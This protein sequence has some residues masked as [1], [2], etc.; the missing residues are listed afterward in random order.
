[1][2]MSVHEQ[3]SPRRTRRQ[4]ATAAN[5]AVAS[6]REDADIAQLAAAEAEARAADHQVKV[7]LAAY[8]I[9]EKRGF[10]PGHEF[11]DWLAAEAEIEKA[12]P[13]SVLTSIQLS[14]AG[15]AS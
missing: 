2:H 4:A 3:K 10:E 9:A 14:P 6:A 7:A 15:S 5:G 12:E 8:F 11:E 1:M 13:P